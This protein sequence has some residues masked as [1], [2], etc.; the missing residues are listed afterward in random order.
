M[1]YFDE[2]KDPCYSTEGLTCVHTQDRGIC[3]SCL[4][5]YLD[6]PTAWYAYGDHPE[7]IYSWQELQKE[8]E[9]WKHAEEVG[10]EPRVEVDESEI[11]W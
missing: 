2:E 7:G 10:L 9:D 1:R 6:D 3:S 11:P 5:K 8:M 4:D